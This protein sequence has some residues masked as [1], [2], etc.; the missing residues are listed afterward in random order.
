ML[1][2]FIKKSKKNIEIYIYLKKEKQ[3]I[4]EVF[5]KEEKYLN[6]INQQN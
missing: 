3:P 5:K 4:I 1:L 2:H 6:M